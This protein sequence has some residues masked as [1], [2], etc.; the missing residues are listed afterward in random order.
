MIRESSMLF[1]CCSIKDLKK[2]FLQKGS[3]GDIV[4]A[5]NDYLA[6]FLVEV[7]LARNHIEFDVETL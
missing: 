1:S 2:K 5:E 3:V 4:L 6:C 7:F